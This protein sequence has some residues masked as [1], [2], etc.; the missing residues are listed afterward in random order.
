M[1]QTLLWIT[2]FDPFLTDLNRHDQLILLG[3]KLSSIVLVFVIRHFAMRLG[4]KCMIA[5]FSIS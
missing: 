2:V 4:F 1:D 5:Q 3:K